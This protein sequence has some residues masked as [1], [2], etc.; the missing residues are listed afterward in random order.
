M[1]DRGFPRYPDQPTNTQINAAKQFHTLSTRF[2]ELEQK[3]AFY[4]KDILYLARHKE[5]EGMAAVTGLSA[6]GNGSVN[7]AL[8]KA[9]S[10]L[11]YIA[12]LLKQLAFALET[13][14]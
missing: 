4:E 7:A 12:N 6:K 13:R 5:V 3:V 2:D 10:D 8:H 9:Q 14:R 11:H 1:K